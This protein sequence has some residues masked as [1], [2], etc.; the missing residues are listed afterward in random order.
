M[1]FGSSAKATTTARSISEDDDNDNGS[2][3]TVVAD[4]GLEF[5]RGRGSNYS[6]PTYQEASGAPLEEHSPLGYHVSAFTLIWL[7]VGEMIGTGVF[8]TRTSL[9]T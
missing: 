2:S 7:G 8:S 9:D 5:V 1:L 3:S 6:Q 4:G